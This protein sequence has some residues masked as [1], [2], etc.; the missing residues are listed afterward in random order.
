MRAPVWRNRGARSKY[1]VSPKDERTYAGRI[2]ASKKEAEYARRLDQL[3]TAR[4]LDRVL[5]WRA[6]VDVP[7]EVNGV[8]ICKYRADFQ[9]WYAG[10]FGGS[11]VEYVEVKGLETEVWRL[12]EKLF[13]AIYPDLVLKVIR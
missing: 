6:Q 2:Y 4:G 3:R 9:V 5:E 8:R 12:K 1:G 11:R 13:R 7:L 10:P